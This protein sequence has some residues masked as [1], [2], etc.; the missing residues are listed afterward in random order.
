MKTAAVS[1]PLLLISLALFSPAVRA[2][3]P[4]HRWS[5]VFGDAG[6]QVAYSAA[7]DAAGNVVIVGWFDGTV[8]FGG[9]ELT[10]AGTLD[11]FV[12]KFDG[13]GAHL[14]SLRTGDAVVQLARSVATDP[15]GNVLVAGTWDDHV[16]VAKFSDA[17]VP[18]WSH[19]FG[20]GGQECRG[21]AT[22]ASG[23]VI[24][25]GE[26]YGTVNFG[27]SDLSSPAFENVFVAKFDGAGVHQW[28]DHFGNSSVQTGLAVATDAGSNVIISGALGGTASFGGPAIT[29]AGYL[30]KFDPSGV[31]QWSKGFNAGGMYSVSADA[32]GNVIAG[33]SFFGTVNFGGSNLTSAGSEDIFI[34][35]FDASGAHQW[36]QKFGDANTQTCRS[37]ATDVDGN[38]FATGYFNTG[39][40]NFGGTDLV[41]ATGNDIFVARFDGAGAHQWSQNFGG[42]SIT[43]A[44]S[45]AA[46]P[47]G[48]VV[49]TGS[50][51]GTASYGGDELT[52]AGG[53]DIFIAMYGDVATGV[54][55]APSTLVI[56]AY[57]NPFNPQATIRFAIPSQGRVT[58][59]VYDAHGSPVTTLLDEEKPAGAFTVA[60]NGRDHGGGAVSSGVYFARLVFGDEQRSYKIVLLK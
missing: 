21:V 35:K 11:I 8:D 32:S 48:N 29:G 28:S 7:T 2:E 41:N 50:L 26:F 39:T 58:I 51:A 55:R 27:G 15:A 37:V 22:D 3:P 54:D 25:T 19:H 38:V 42:S 30:V 13:T 49:I 10:T 9:D 33:G 36:S 12:A 47:D 14:W 53:H 59:A 24:I 23:N 6:G 43:S 1:L 18:Q 44:Y 5:Q 16:Y 4:A 57:P 56:S 40:V 20:D 52:G 45:V 46:N 60:W 31:H 17:G 34:A